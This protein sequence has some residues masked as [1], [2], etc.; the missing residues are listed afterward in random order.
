MRFRLYCQRLMLLTALLTQAVSCAV[1][2]AQEPAAANMQ[3]APKQEPERLLFFC[4]S[5]MCNGSNSYTI[6]KGMGETYPGDLWDRVNAACPDGYTVESGPVSP[7]ICVDVDVTDVDSLSATQAKVASSASTR[8]RVHGYLCYCDGSPGRDLTTSGDSYCEAVQK[9]RR[10]LIKLKDPC[11]RA[12]LK[13]CVV[14]SPA[15]QHS[16][17]PQR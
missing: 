14:E 16:C 8:W 1:S 4:V 12:Y 11:K 3:V 9:A 2:N 5:I 13:F 6:V 15:P 10:I 7:D 17:C